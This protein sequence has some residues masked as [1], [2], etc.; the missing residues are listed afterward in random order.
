[1]AGLKNLK[2]FNFERNKYFYGKLLNVEDFET[3]QRYM[4]DKRRLLNRLIHGMGVVCGMYVVGVDEDSITVEMGVAL[5]FAGRE[6][7]VEHPVLKKLST[8]DG[9]TDYK[10]EDEANHSLYLYIEYQE[11]EKEPVYSIAARG[12]GASRE[13]FNKYQEG[14]HLYLSAKEPDADWIGGNLYQ[15]TQTVYQENGIRIQQIVPRYIE[16]NREFAITIRVEKESQERGISFSYQLLLD[17]VETIGSEKEEVSFLEADYPKA[18]A[19]TI[20]KRFHALPVKGVNG[21]I[22]VKAESFLIRFGGKER[23]LSVDV[24]SSFF[25]TDKNV[26]QEFL[27][28]YYK[29]A[30]EDIVESTTIQGICLARISVIRAGGT[31]LIDQVEAM[32]FRQFVYTNPLAQ[33][34]NE[35]TFLED[36]KVYHT[37]SEWNQEYTMDRRNLPNQQVAFGDAVILLGLG[38]LR[39]QKFFSEEIVHG[40]GLGMVYLSL[41]VACER[42]DSSEIV[43][44]AQDIFERKGHQVALKMAAKIDVT[45]GSFRIGVECLEDTAEQQVRIHWIALKD[46]RERIQR[47][48]I[49]TLRIQ[50]DMASVSVRESCCFTAILQGVKNGRV[51]WSVKEAGGGSIDENGIYTA[52]NQSGVYEILARSMDDEK[53]MAS[54][55]VVVRDG[56]C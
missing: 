5:D 2:Y 41:G 7:V 38:G 17:G 15:E 51:F 44:G 39:G 9:F 53:V 22:R 50:P 6:I 48:E 14:Y 30:M 27:E 1:M 25:I 31:Y 55:F 4:N 11:I 32:P 42:S 24:T 8:I 18:S 43:Y 45:R 40:L 28:Q 13:E 46:D 21:S 26:K 54:T 37:G 12:E 3:E 47:K 56:M 20:V 29:S 10:E 33:V 34:M 36:R 23:T 19:Y 35:L 49:R 52:P 16:S